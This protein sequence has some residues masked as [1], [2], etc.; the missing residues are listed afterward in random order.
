MK[1]SAIYVYKNS[2]ILLDRWL[3]NSANERWQEC[4]SGI[5]TNEPIAAVRTKNSS[6]LRMQ[7]NVLSVSITC[8]KAS[9]EV[10]YGPVS[11]TIMAFIKKST[12]ESC[13]GLISRLGTHPSRQEVLTENHHTVTE[14]RLPIGDRIAC[15]AKYQSGPQR[16]REEQLLRHY[17]YYT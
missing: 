14:A 6:L 11:E 3:A 2:W 15:Q 13:G 17:R 7:N 16:V 10:N 8:Y 4:D 5:G 1:G 12:Y 9:L